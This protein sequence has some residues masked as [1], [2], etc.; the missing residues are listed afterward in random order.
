MHDTRHEP[1][2]G[3]SIESPEHN[4]ATE[5]PKDEAASPIPLRASRFPHAATVSFLPSGR[6][7]SSALIAGVIA[8]VLSVLLTILTIHYMRLG[9]YQG[10]SLWKRTSRQASSTRA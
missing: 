2:T 5:F 7:L 9:K 6:G 4:E 3:H 10:W 8:S 1:T